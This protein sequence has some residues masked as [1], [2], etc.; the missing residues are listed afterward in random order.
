MSSKDSM[1]IVDDSKLARMIIRGFASESLPDMEIVEA[2]NGEEALEISNG[3]QFTVMT[4]DYNM[5]G[6]N[7]LGLELAQKLKDVSPNAHIS[8]IT[9]NIQVSIQKRTEEMKINFIP[10]PINERKK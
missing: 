7:G 2:A 6:I 1:L 3:K 4:I 10:K 8:L 9:A 5:P